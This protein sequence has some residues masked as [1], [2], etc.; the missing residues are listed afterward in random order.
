[1]AT[2]IDV[3]TVRPERQG[4]HMAAVSQLAEGS[5]PLL[6]VVRIGP[7][8]LTASP[9]AARPSPEPARPPCLRPVSSGTW[10]SCLTRLLGLQKGEAHVGLWFGIRRSASARRSLIALAALA[11]AAV[12]AAGCGSGNSGSSGSGSN[13]GSGS[14]GIYGGGSSGNAKAS[15][16]ATVTAT[17]TKLGSILVGVGSRTLYV[18]DKDKANQS[19]CSGG[20]AAA[21]PVEQTSGAPKAGSSSVNASMLGTIKRSVGTTQVTYN[22]HPLYYY[23]GDSQAGQQN[24]Q[25]LNAFGAKWFVV[26]PSGNQVT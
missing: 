12:V 23:S 26:A 17:N 16:P 25:G 13:S 4:E 6:Y 1:V 2:L 3:F 20:C 21:W 19:A 5:D 10:A 15:G 7:S 8:R 24:G 22:H 18:F 11:I 14:G 9:S